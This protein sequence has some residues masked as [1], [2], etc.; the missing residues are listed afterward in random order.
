MKPGLLIGLTLALATDALAHRLDEYLQA[1]RVA[2]ST[3][4]IDLSIELTPGVAVASQVLGVI[5]KNR[6]GQISTAERDQYGE[7]FLKD[8][9]IKVDEKVSVLRLVDVSFPSVFEMQS[10][11]GVIRLKATATTGPL[12]EGKHSLCLTNAHAPLVSVYLVNALTPKTPAV[13]ITRQTRDELQKDYR[14][15]FEVISAKKQPGQH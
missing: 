3:N 13:Q 8:V 10:G 2:V 6:D 12:M 7:Q 4:Q 14:L 1:T 15:E 9:Q 5:D 11:V